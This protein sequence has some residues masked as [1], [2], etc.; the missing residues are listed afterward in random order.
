MSVISEPGYNDA[1][2]EYFNLPKLFGSID[3]DVLLRI[4]DTN[5]D[6]AAR[7]PS[8][9]ALR[10]HE[11]AASAYT[12]A[13]LVLSE[14]EDDIDVLLAYMDA[15]EPHFLAA[16]M[17]E[18]RHLETGFCRPDQQ[19]RWLRADLQCE[20]MT[21]YRDI[22]CG[23]VTE[24]TC[25]EMLYALEK[26]IKH[27]AVLPN[28]SQNG[29]GGLLYELRILRDFWRAYRNPGDTVAFPS[30][31]RGNEGNARPQ[32]T[33]DIILAHQIDGTWRF[34]GREIKGGNA[35]TLA[36]LGRYTNP[37]IHVRHDGTV[38]EY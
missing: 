18:F 33:H 17:E 5:A 6:M 26:K 15:A 38:A 12:E 36:V 19:D 25:S 29:L 35:L 4:A 14:R 2:G 9:A 3:P 34:A 1:S 7:L 11:V 37:I 24:Q 16:A 30:S 10:Y 31:A 23:E 27:T 20:F 21:V 8:V 28:K 22:V 32:E 13:A